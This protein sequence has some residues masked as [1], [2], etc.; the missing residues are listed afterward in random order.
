MN[1]SY[2]IVIPA[3]AGIQER[4]VDDPPEDAIRELS[5]MSLD[6]SEKKHKGSRKEKLSEKPDGAIIGFL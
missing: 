3:K 2:I 5:F 6:G 1:T 4:S